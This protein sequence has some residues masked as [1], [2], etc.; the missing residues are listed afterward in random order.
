MEWNSPV[1][2]L[3]AA[4]A[5][6]LLALSGHLVE[7]R[8]RNL[9][10][11]FSTAS[12]LAYAEPSAGRRLFRWTLMAASAGLLCLGLADP[13]YGVEI[14]EIFH[15]GRDIVFVLDVS[16]SMLAT[17]IAP[18][19]MLRA[20]YDIAEQAARV[21][22][23][24]LGLIV[25]AGNNKEL[26]PLTYDYHHF[27]RC[28]KG[29]EPSSVVRGGTNLGDAIRRAMALIEA[30]A[31]LGNYK[32]IVLITDGQD[33]EGFYEEAAR[34]AGKKGISIYTV[35]IGQ[36]AETAIRLSDG[37]YVMH[38]GKK[39][40]TALNPEPLL[41]VSSLSGGTYH[42]LAASPDW[43]SRI[44]DDI[45]RKEQSFSP[46]ERRER[47]TPRFHYFV[48]LALALWAAAAMLGDRPGRSPA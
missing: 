32:D 39:V 46:L 45:E 18:S 34:E 15:R 9:C 4:A 22:G 48:G 44:L 24:R 20:K 31:R 35:G 11:L 43:V 42:N 2:L 13:R 14:R 21:Q 28:L 3:A 30:G 37:S 25:F 12:S 17:D 8:K 1:W 19:R 27:V 36:S 29:A 40:M 5:L 33:L 10:R 38:D 6:P 26:C 47:K 7:A 16:R 41:L 23:H